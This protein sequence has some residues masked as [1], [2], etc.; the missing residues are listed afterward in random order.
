MCLWCFPLPNER[1]II[2]FRNWLPN[3]ERP[4]L[5]ELI[6]VIRKSNGNCASLPQ[7]IRPCNV[8]SGPFDG[9][10]MQAFWLIYGNPNKQSVH[11][12]LVKQ[13]HG[14]KDIWVDTNVGK[15]DVKQAIDQARQTAL[16][17]KTDYAYF[18]RII[19]HFI[20]V[21][22]EQNNV[23]CSILLQTAEFGGEYWQPRRICI[24]DEIAALEASS[25]DTLNPTMIS[26]ILEESGDWPLDQKFASSWFEDDASVEDI[27]N[28]IAPSYLLPM[29]LAQLNIKVLEKVIELKRNIWR[30]RCLLMALWTKA[31]QSQN[32]AL[33][34]AHLINARALHQGIALHEIPLMNGVAIRSIFSAKNRVE[35]IR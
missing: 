26:K 18:K 5:D 23:P 9:A 3:D 21:G 10:G 33:W 4:A 27:L 28:D 1:R 25:P 2:G 8:Y 6:R 7:P 35:S 29:Q 20:D 13:N 14:I 11:R 22:L 16:S 15:R 34:K 12:L 30:E 32:N 24:S 17:T 19:S 31:S